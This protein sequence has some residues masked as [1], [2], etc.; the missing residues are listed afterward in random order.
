MDRRTDGHVYITLKTECFLRVVV[1]LTKH[2]KGSLQSS[3]DSKISP[4]L[5]L[6]QHTHIYA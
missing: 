3:D 2:T 1:E 4:V 5:K 6:L